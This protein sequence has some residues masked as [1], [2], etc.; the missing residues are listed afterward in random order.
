MVIIFLDFDG[1]CTRSSL[2]AIS[3]AENQLFG[4]LPR[5]E[6]V[7]RDFPIAKIVIASDWRKRHSVDELREFFSPDIRDRIVGVTPVLGVDAYTPGGRQS[8]VEAY[9]LR[10]GF[11]NELWVA[12]DDERD[13]YRPDAPLV[14]C[15]DGFF[16]KEEAALIRMLLR[17]EIAIAVQGASES[18]DQTL[19][20]S[21]RQLSSLEP[22]LSKQLAETFGSEVGAMRW[23]SRRLVGTHESPAML[24]GQGR[25]QEIEVVLYR[26]A[27]GVL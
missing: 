14:C 8:E 10:A 3:D 26:I 13:R 6:S 1:Y 9:L 18:F 17:A 11:E 5:F 21:F 24:L 7:I 22:E 2:G 4:T 16:A 15:D 12:L 23:L 20:E 19:V 27:H 25:L